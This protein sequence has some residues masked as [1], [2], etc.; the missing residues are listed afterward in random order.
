MS[1]FKARDWW[2]WRVEGGSEE[3]DRGNMVVDNVDNDPS[4]SLKIV[5]GSFQGVLRIFSPRQRDYR[6][7]DLILEQELDA[8]VLQLATG[9]FVPNLNQVALAVLHPRKL[10]V[11]TVQA[12]G[13]SAGQAGYYTLNKNYEH[14]LDRTAYN[15][16]HGPF[17]GVYDKDYL[18]VQS[19]DGCLYFFEQDTFA[20]SRFLSN[21]LVPGPLCYSARLDSFIT[22][23]SV[24]DIEAYKYGSLA[25]STAERKAEGGDAGGGKRV[26]VDWSVNIGE[27]VLDIQIGRFTRSQPA[28]QND[29]VVLTERGLYCVREQGQIRFQKRLDY[30]PSAIALYPCGDDPSQHSAVVANHNSM[31]MFYKEAQLIWSAG[32]QSVP[33]ALAVA[34]FGGLSGL[35]VSLDDAGQLAVAYLGTDPPTTVV[36]AFESNKELNYEEMDDEHRRLLAIIR[37]ATSENRTE[38]SERIVIKAQV[39]PRLDPSSGLPAGEDGDD[40]GWQ[41]GAGWR[42]RGVTVRLF[43]SYTGPERIEDVTLTVAPAPP[44]T[45]SHDI[46]HIP[47][48]AGARGTPATVTLLFRCRPDALPTSLTAEVAA[49]YRSPQGEPRV[50]RATIALPLAL[51]VAPVA[52]LKN[53]TFKIT[54]ETN[55]PPPPLAALFGD[56]VQGTP[57]G[58]AKAAAAGGV[59]TLQFFAGPDVTILVSKNAGRYRIQSG[60]FEALQLAA[61]QLCA[62]LEA[63]FGRHVAA[64]EEPLQ[65]SFQ[66]ALPLHDYFAVIDEHFRCRERC[67]EADKVLAER[68]QQ[69]RAVQKRLLVRFKDRNPAPLSHLDTLLAQT[70]EGLMELAREAEQRQRSLKEAAGRLS[71]ATRLVCLLVKLRFGLDEENAK[72]LEAHLTPVVAD[73][74][75]QGWEECVEAAMTQLLRTA[76]AKN[77]KEAGSGPQPLTRA[78]DTVRLKKH[79]TLVCDRLSKGA[80]IALSSAPPPP[81]P[82]RDPPAP[83]SGQ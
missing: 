58:D 45:V 14:S 70:Y 11:Y 61:E 82:A 41:H 59:L 8:P 57:F 39:P 38:P 23:N 13:G 4:G 67:R 62:R 5:I 29:I 64:G 74:P 18:C 77:A 22:F 47:A 17:G 72:Q 55:R 75:D 44:L 19:M 26:Q 50:S 80:R 20:F 34:T 68:S 25:A 53:A 56:L 24:M 30:F 21:F 54:I 10:A 78:T 1:L 73:T 40:E 48:V 52:P 31:L 6:V 66:E 65:I 81:A 43:L 51:A 16:C 63:H 3:F 79:I 83:E 28:N 36:G 7:E 2:S 9:R 27:Q 76:L 46:L 15:M 71:V 33:V 32:C 42:G 37:E 49:A 69:F 60:A 12:A 35:V